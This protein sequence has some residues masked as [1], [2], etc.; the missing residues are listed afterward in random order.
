MPTQRNRTRPLDRGRE[1]YVNLQ[2][3][4]AFDSLSEADRNEALGLDDLERLAITADMLGREEVL[5][6]TER[7]HQLARR[8]GDV[9]R[10]VRAAFWLGMALADRGEWS[11]AGGWFAKAERELDEAGLDSVE[12]GYLLVPRGEQRVAEGDP[13]AALATYDEVVAIGQRFADL[14]LVTLGRVGRG[15][16][17]IASGNA[18]GGMTQLD[19]AMVAVVADEVSPL[20]AGIVYCSVI[21]ACQSTFDLR[22]A[23]EWTGALSQWCERQPD[24]VPFRG[25][26]LLSRARLMHLR[27]LWREAE[28]EARLARERLTVQRDPALGDAVYFQAELH[29]LRG[30]FAEAEKDYRKASELG[31]APE[32][33]LAQLR[34]AQGRTEAASAM[35][36]RAL[37]EAT[38]RATR[39]WLLDAAVEIAMAA[40]DIQ[41]ATGAAAELS[42]IASTL[43]APMLAAMSSRAEG[44]VLLAAGDAAAALVHLRRSQATWKALDAPFELAR[45]RLLIARACHQLGDTDTA[46]LE[47][48]HAYRVFRDLGA[49]AELAR[50]QALVRRPS[51]QLPGGLTPREAE[52][53][54]LV[55]SGKTNRAIAGDLVLSEKTVARHLSNIFTKLGISSRAAATAYAYEHGL[56]AGQH[57]GLDDMPGT[58]GSR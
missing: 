17:L 6:V 3:K 26:C 5:E 18:R 2:W 46:E 25:Q 36:R 7:A 43:R 23:Q 27:G 35:I 34:L 9:G 19:E 44:A 54:R 29:R 14:D 11:Q 47:T 40:G 58:S 50:V 53:L 48:D 39:A 15:E 20:I 57:M 31:R 55:A 52:I 16:S 42:T 45:T 22:R 41:A 24:M 51:E 37:G 13:H 10:A 8:A 4:V 21:G 56:V 1:A 33:G 12:R 32:P 49:T 30:G 28:R 38:E